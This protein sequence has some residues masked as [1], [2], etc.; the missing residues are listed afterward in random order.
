MRIS[1]A[2]IDCYVSIS[3]TMDPT[4]SDFQHHH[5]EIMPSGQ[6][7]TGTL[8]N[9]PTYT[10]TV[11]SFGKD[12]SGTWSTPMGQ[13]FPVNNGAQARITSPNTVSLNQTVGFGVHKLPVIGSVKATEHEVAEMIWMIPAP[14]GGT[15]QN[16]ITWN[17]NLPPSTFTHQDTGYL[18]YKW[19]S[20][21]SLIPTGQTF[22]GRSILA[23]VTNYAVDLA[24]P[25]GVVGGRDWT[26]GALTLYQVPSARA[27]AW[28]T[29][30]ITLVL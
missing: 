28:W 17:A 1:T 20:T 9:I 3:S 2:T 6:I 5:W 25:T 7:G 4:Y 27:L 8:N 10:W 29:W 15:P 12:S 19:T 23:F 14:P 26:T 21:L 30:T 18:T 24:S 13:S 22:F 16:L 11:N